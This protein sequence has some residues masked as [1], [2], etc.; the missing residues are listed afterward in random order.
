MKKD[1]DHIAKD[2]DTDFTFSE[3]G[4]GQRN[5]VYKF[6]HKLPNKLKILELNCGTGEDAIWL[7]KQNNQVLATDISLEMIAVAKQ[8]AIE[9]DNLKFKQLDINNLDF[10][11]IDDRRKTKN[12]KFDIIFSNFGGLNCLNPS[13]IKKFFKN[14]SKISNKSGKLILVIM[15][16]NTL[17]ERLYFTLKGQ[18]KKAKRRNTY[19]SIN[20][21]VAG[22]QVKTWYYNPKDIKKMASPYFKVVARKPIGFFIPPSYLENYFVKHKRFL[23]FLY[24]LE[25][26]MTKFGFLSKYSDHY[27]IELEICKS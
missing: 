15:P 17:W 4:K 2:Y 12:S 7:A 26:R 19:D 1:F 20:V 6:L 25:K 27:L 21:N 18:F 9:I 11:L 5:S 14:A 10:R 22:K 16:K 23:S 8:K 13:E 24:L 3:I